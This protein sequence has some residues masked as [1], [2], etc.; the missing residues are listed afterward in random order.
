MS[1]MDL[2]QHALQGPQELERDLALHSYPLG[3]HCLVKTWLAWRVLLGLGP[4][5]SE[6]DTRIIK[7]S[8]TVCFALNCETMARSCV[9]S[10]CLIS[11]VARAT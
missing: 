6:A 7:F 8:G 5:K 9:G 4:F 1:G 11:G 2:S 3:L 10:Q